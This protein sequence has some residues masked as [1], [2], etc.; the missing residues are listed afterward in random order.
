[1]STI[2]SRQ[3]DRDHDRHLP[4]LVGRDGKVGD[5]ALGRLLLIQA[6]FLESSQHARRSSVIF[7]LFVL[8]LRVGL[9]GAHIARLV[10]DQSW[11]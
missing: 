7:V 1:M 4:R 2:A 9:V 3:T 6:Q 8:R 11:S 5:L 10:F